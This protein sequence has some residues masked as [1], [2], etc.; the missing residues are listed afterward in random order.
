MMRLINTGNDGSGEARRK[1]RTSLTLLLG[2]M[3]TGISGFI[4]YMALFEGFIGPAQMA[5]YQDRMWIAS[6][7]E[8]HRFNPLGQRVDHTPLASFGLSA[9]ISDLQVLDDDAFLTHDQDRFVECSFSR[10][11]CA[12]LAVAGDFG[13][14]DGRRMQLSTDGLQ[15]AIA[16]TSAHR[17]IL[18][19]RESR[20]SPYQK[21]KILTL[22]FR[23]PNQ[24]RWENS[25]LLV[26]NTNHN[27]LTRVTDPFGAASLQTISIKH[28]Q[29]R[30]GRRWP[31]ALARIDAAQLA[32]LVASATMSNADLLIL[33]DRE[34]STVIALEATQDPFSI[35]TV[36]PLLLISDPH[37]FKV[38]Q[39]DGARVLPDGFGDADFKREL[40]DAKQ[41]EQ[42]QQRLPK[43]LIGFIVVCLLI[44]LVLARKAGELTQIAGASWATPEATGLDDAGALQDGRVTRITPLPAVTRNRRTASAAL[45]AI[46]VL[47]LCMLTYIAWPYFYNHDCGRHTHCDTWGVMRLL[48]IA[49]PVTFAALVLAVWLRLRELDH[50]SLATNGQMLFVTS[51][52]HVRALP[53]TQA[54]LTR[55]ALLIRS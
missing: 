14:R 10:A 3:I 27:E 35:A 28:P 42:W 11:A 51:G 52:K 4:A 30:S 43:V 18:F 7:G 46:S 54:T 50:Q 21:R 36:G 47:V 40:E 13:R 24:M 2:V 31:F 16:D 29:L 49:V 26:A 41:R 32:V 22:E 55:Q 44:G 17:V 34:D 20:T 23:F 12:P 33:R 37:A 53:A 19:S 6:H 8:L 38:W 25:D 15:L 5:S 48:W 1:Y 39:H 9:K 45:G